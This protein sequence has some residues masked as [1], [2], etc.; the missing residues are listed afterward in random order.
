MQPLAR[1]CAA[2]AA[3]HLRTFLEAP[4]AR[5]RSGVFFVGGLVVGFGFAPLAVSPAVCAYVEGAGLAICDLVVSNS[6]RGNHE[7]DGAVERRRA[8]EKRSHLD[9]SSGQS[10][11]IP[12]Q[13]LQKPQL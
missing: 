2:V 7:E 12:A 11:I 9:H 3:D 8:R 13:Y 1:L 5:G 4:T 10:H 6:T